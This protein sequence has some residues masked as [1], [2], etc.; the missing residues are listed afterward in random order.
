MTFAAR[1]KKGELDTMKFKRI[2]HEL[3]ATLMDNWSLEL[4]IL[5]I[6]KIDSLANWDEIKLTRRYEFDS[7]YDYLRRMFINLRICTPYYLRF[8]LH[9]E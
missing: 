8:K 4:D 2:S 1:K 3:I 7:D 6:S 9:I 5:P